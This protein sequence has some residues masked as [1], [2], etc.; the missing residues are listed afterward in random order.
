M[1]AKMGKQA[2]RFIIKKLPNA[3]ASAYRI[4]S[5]GNLVSSHISS[6][7]GPDVKWL[8]NLAI[9]VNETKDPYA[10]LGLGI[11][12]MRARLDAAKYLSEW[13]GQRDVIDY[14]VSAEFGYH[15]ELDGA[16]DISYEAFRLQH[17]LLSMTESEEERAFGQ[18]AAIMGVSQLAVKSLDDVLE[19]RPL[20]V[21]T[22]SDRLNLPSLIANWM[23]VGTVSRTLL[24]KGDA[25]ANLPALVADSITQILVDSVSTE[26]RQQDLVKE[27]K[28]FHFQIANDVSAMRTWL[29]HSRE[30]KESDAYVDTAVPVIQALVP[31]QRGVN[32]F[33]G[34]TTLSHLKSGS[35]YSDIIRRKMETEKLA[36]LDKK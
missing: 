22:F 18:L 34:H 10:L 29:T 23:G 14:I 16:S 4:Y 19:G 30:Y 26:Q 2:T 33:S 20:S 6:R 25:P 28:D 15:K 9:K 8:E 17:D 5:V 35:S 13:R 12:N 31:D 27:I 32:S 3:A 21:K 1:I 36:R 7:K 11:I 24:L